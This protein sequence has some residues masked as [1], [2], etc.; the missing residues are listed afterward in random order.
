MILSGNG[1]ELSITGKNLT[2]AVTAEFERKDLSGQTSSASFAVDS[3]KKSVSVSLQIP[4]DEKELLEQIHVLAAALDEKG[5][6]IIFS[7]VDDQCALAKIRQVIFAGSLRSQKAPGLL[8][9]DVSFD[10]KEQNPALAKREE[11]IQEKAAAAAST[12]TDG[13][14]AV[15]SVDHAKVVEAAK[16]QGGTVSNSS[17]NSV[18]QAVSKAI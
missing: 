5:D 15:G 2:V 6:P 10:L 8:C 13:A 18:T 4:F 3:T 1:Y 11:R 12:T 7:I 9:W 17:G 14:Q 16:L